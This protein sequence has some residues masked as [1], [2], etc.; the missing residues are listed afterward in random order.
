MVGV[1]AMVS[2]SACIRELFS[3]VPRVSGRSGWVV[4]YV[5]GTSVA[6]VIGLW[7]VGE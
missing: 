3:W 2:V 4:I 7:M 1:A 6:W 5:G